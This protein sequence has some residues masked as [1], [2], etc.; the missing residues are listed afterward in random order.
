Y[1]VEELLTGQGPGLIGTGRKGDL[2]RIA[3][4]ELRRL[5]RLDVFDRL[6]EPL[7][8]LFKAL[9]GVGCARHLAM[10]EPCAGLGREIAGE[11][12]LLGERQHV[13]IKPRS[14]QHLGLDIFGFAM[15]FGLG[16]DAGE[17]TQNLQEG[18]N[19]GV[20]E[21]HVMLFSWEGIAK[22]SFRWSLRW[23]DATA[24]FYCAAEV[25]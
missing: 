16:E 22:R 13:R 1:V 18:R 4:V 17:A 10:G 24:F 8:Q 14:Q 15:R 3:A 25:G 19:G 7:L 21:G 12:D 2:F 9:L 6:T 23:K 11:L 20:V 5:E